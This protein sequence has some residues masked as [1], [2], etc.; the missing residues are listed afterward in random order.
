LF[1]KDWFEVDFTQRRLWLSTRPQQSARRIT[2]TLLFEIIRFDAS[3]WPFGVL[4]SPACV[5]LQPLCNQAPNEPFS[6]NFAYSGVF[7][8]KLLTSTLEE[9]FAF[10]LGVDLA[11]QILH[12]IRMRC[13]DEVALPMRAATS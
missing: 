4:E 3:L 6:A 2:A 12:E 10:C 9:L 5:N 13:H 1:A 8:L 11:F 7:A